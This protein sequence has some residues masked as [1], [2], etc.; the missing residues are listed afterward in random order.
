MDG[1]F[2]RNAFDCVDEIL[3]RRAR[4]DASAFTHPPV[5]GRELHDVIFALGIEDVLSEA[6]GG[7]ECRSSYARSL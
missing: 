4:C 5:L 6:S 1:Y 7:N 2:F 3:R